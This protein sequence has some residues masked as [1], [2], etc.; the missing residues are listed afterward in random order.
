MT[1]KERQLV[2]DIRQ[3]QRFG[4]GMAMSDGEFKGW[5]VQQY[6]ISEEKLTD[7]MREDL[8]T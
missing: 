1:S 7:L 3:A 5:A 8:A 2:R 6:G 4:V